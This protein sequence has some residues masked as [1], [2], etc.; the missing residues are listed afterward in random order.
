[1]PE[2]IRAWTASV[3]LWLQTPL[4]FAVASYL[5]IALATF[6][7]KARSPEQYASTAARRPVWFWSRVAA[8][9]QFLGGLGMD[10]SKVAT[11]L[12]KIL[13]GRVDPPTT[14][15]SSGPPTLREPPVGTYTPANH[16]SMSAMK[17]VAL[18]AGVVIGLCIGASFI[19]GCTP[20][21]RRDVR[22]ALSFAQAACIVA[23]QALPDS[24]VAEICGVAGPF[25]GPMHELL[26]SARAETAAARRAGSSVCDGG[27]P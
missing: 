21:Q 26:T 22:D 7:F 13:T 10:P 5:C 19:S 6:L 3:H 15:P 8:F 4:G 16:D 1:M 24:K 11:A 25:F 20:A 27:A 17:R 9:W 2:F 14:P 12:V 18:L 23:N